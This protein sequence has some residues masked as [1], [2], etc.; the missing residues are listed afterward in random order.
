MDVW[1]VAAPLCTLQSHDDEKEHARRKQHH[2]LCAVVSRHM[3]GRA[4]RA[5]PAKLDGAF[6]LGLEEPIRESEDRNVN[7]SLRNGIPEACLSFLHCLES[8]AAVSSNVLRHLL[9]L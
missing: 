7:V 5:R 3:R 9:A 8:L 4:L 2:A 1:A 6:P